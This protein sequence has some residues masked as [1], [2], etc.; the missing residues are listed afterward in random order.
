M[1]H[2]IKSSFRGTSV[3]YKL[4]NGLECE[5]CDDSC[6]TC[7]N[8][9]GCLTCNEEYWRK[10]QTDGYCQ[11]FST[12]IGCV[13]KTKEG[14]KECDNG[15]YLSVCGFL[16]YSSSHVKHPFS[17]KH[18]AQLSSHFSHSNPLSSLK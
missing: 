7:L 18:V 15:Y 1:A 3:Y 8:E 12:L 2:K 14:C 9:K 13:N 10:P 11:P 17:F 16:Q 6:E 5:Q 4:E